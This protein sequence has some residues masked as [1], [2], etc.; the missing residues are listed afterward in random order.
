[1]MRRQHGFTL[2]EL[3]IAMALGIFVVGAIFGVFSNQTKQL[4]YQDLQMEMHQSLRLAT[5]SV[6]RT[7]RM[8]GYGTDGQTLGILGFAGGSASTA[9]A[10]P[11]II[12]YDGTGPNGS[13][14]ITVVTMD[15][16]LSMYTNF[17]MPADCSSNRLPF[18]TTVFDNDAKL[19]QFSAGEMVMCMDYAPIGGYTS[20]IWQISSVD[21]NNGE[22]VVCSRA[23]VAT[24]Y[25]DNDDTDGIGAGSSSNP[26]LMMDLDF[27]APGANDVPV[28]DNIED[29]QFEYCL[30][31]TIGATTCDTTAAWVNTIDDYND[32]NNANDPDDVYMIRASFIVRSSREDPQ[33]LYAGSR[34]ALA[35]NTAG[36]G[37]DHYF[38]QAQSTEVTVRNMRLLNLP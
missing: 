31:S 32:N 25:I 19:A 12:S 3:M 9:Q 35:N 33:D 26:V 4:V 38:R 28:V 6:S 20:Y 29:M 7:A 14:A 16:G 17:S 10:M 37:T 1:M 30:R 23:E 22:L 27:N 36:S 15:P 13:D 34:P 21:T 11:A 18:N 2:I 24:F 5:D 8:G